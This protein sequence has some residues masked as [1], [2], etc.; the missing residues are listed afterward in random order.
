MYVLFKFHIFI[1]VSKHAL[2]SHLLYFI[3]CRFY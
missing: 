3:L 1:E 2:Y